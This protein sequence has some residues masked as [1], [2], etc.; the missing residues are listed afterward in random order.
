[1]ETT[2]KEKSN[3]LTREIFKKR[4]KL[5]L[6]KKLTIITVAIF[7]LSGV[8]EASLLKLLTSLF[9]NDL[10]L[11]IVSLGIGILVVSIGSAI[12]IRIFLRKPLKQLTDLGINLSNNN[13]TYKTDIK[14][15]DELG[16]LGESLNESV[17]N[18]RLLIEG[19]LSNSDNIQGAS[20]E[21]YNLLD[22]IESN[23]ETNH[24][25]VQ[26]FAGAMEE[27]SAAIEEVNSAIKEVTSIT[28]MLSEKAQE[29]SN[30]SN[31]IDIRANRLKETT[32]EDINNA[33]E[34]YKE[35]HG[36]ILKSIER[37]KVTS[38]IEKMTSQI[39]QI[40]EQINLLA[41]NA[42]IESA[43]AGE[44]GKG[45]AVVA[46]EVRKLAEQV[47]ETNGNIE[48]VTKDINDV[49]LDL[50]ENA[51]EILKYIDEDV[52]N[53]YSKIM[54]FGNKYIED[55]KSINML[56]EEIS[57]TSQQ[58]FASMEEMECAVE[59]VSASVEQSSANIQ[60]ISS[61]ITETTHKTKDIN[62]KNKILHEMTNELNERIKEF[63]I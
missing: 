62:N 8:I 59:S 57:V 17:G 43:R 54:E 35:I 51:K 39:E 13:L 1:M 15:K 47:S 26:E 14:S 22:D 55:S 9:S 25:Y 27:S 44:H 49:M 63:T 3:K 41:L 56:V 32:K 52:S 40:S 31:E 20:N 18:L 33:N 29:G 37:S 23:S 19:I 7:F 11:D 34:L 28:K 46:E 5:N 21:I 61:N 6:H 24:G 10:A 38:E 2:I 60:E 48:L 50:S 4:V 12:F 53:N 45:F 42:A 58:V 16:L 30:L 36:K